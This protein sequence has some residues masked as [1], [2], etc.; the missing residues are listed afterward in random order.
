MGTEYDPPVESGVKL[1][2]LNSSISDVIQPI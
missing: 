1:A 2:P